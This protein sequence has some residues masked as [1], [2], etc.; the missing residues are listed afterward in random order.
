MTSVVRYIDQAYDQ[1]DAG[2]VLASAP[3]NSTGKDYQFIVRKIPLTAALPHNANYDLFKW[4]G[5]GSIIHIAG[6]RVVTNA[7]VP[8]P[9]ATADL[10]TTTAITIRDNGKTIRVAIGNDAALAYPANAVI[11]F[12]L[13]I[14]NY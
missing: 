12:M 5:T 6:V 10:V 14:G 7:G 13:V 8:V 1:T 4:T 11:T 2:T 9:Q 3:S